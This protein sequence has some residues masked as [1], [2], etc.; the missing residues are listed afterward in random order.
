MVITGTILRLEKELLFP[1]NSSYTSIAHDFR[2]RATYWLKIAML[3]TPLVTE[4][5]SEFSKD[6]QLCINL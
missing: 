6:V 3:Y 1:F 5:P 4:T 2:D